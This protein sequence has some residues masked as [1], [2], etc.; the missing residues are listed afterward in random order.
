[1]ADTVSPATRSRVMAA[2]KGKDTAPELM[3]RRC[4]HSLGFRYRLHVAG[5]PGKPDLVFPRLRKIIE[6][7]G[8]FWHGHRCGRC[9]IPATRR[10]YWLNK[11]RRNVER[12]QSNLSRL[13][14][15]GWRVLVLWECRLADERRLRGRLLAFLSKP[16]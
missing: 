3:V 7:R 1:M 10:R 5:L 14:R 9:R 8:C 12:D 4:V 2:V 15:S 6:V 16:G 13:R 11:L